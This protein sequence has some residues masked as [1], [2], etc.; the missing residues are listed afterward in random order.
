MKLQDEIEHVLAYFDVFSYPPSMTEIHTFLSVPVSRLKLTQKLREMVRLGRIVSSSSDELRYSFS[1]T[2]TNFEQYKG[3]RQ[4]SQDKIDSVNLYFKLL[5]MF[6]GIRFAGISGSLSMM[7]GR[8]NDDIDICIIT[9]PGCLW[10]GRLYAVVCAALLGKKRSYK[11]RNP[12]NKICLNLFFDGTNLKIPQ[13]KQ[14]EYVAHEL[15]Q[16]IPVIDK[17]E[18]YSAFIQKNSWVCELFPNYRAPKGEVIKKV[19][20]SFPWNVFEP[21][22]KK[23]QM[24]SIT[25]RKTSELITDTQLWFYP[26]DFEKK[27][28]KKF[29]LREIRV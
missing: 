4:I 26:Q 25:K 15:L 27:F 29:S 7:N 2:S 18:I 9:S 22:L 10:T 21:F 13:N 6:P 20:G 5:S 12:V 3:R 17:G 28:K 19:Y 24:I 14:N 23:L 1:T 11:E 8:P 16:L